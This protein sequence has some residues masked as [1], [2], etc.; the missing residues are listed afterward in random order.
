MK[1]LN[2][3][4][5]G[6]GRSGR[7]IHAANLQRLK[8]KFQVTAI[9]EP[10]EKRRERAEKEF[11]CAV[12][13]DYTELFAQVSEIDLVVNS[14]PSHFHVPVTLDLLKNGF[15][16]LCEKP[17]ARTA[18]EVDSMIETAEK[19]KRLLAVFQQSRFNESYREV[20]RIIDSGILG[21]II[22][23]SV[24]YSGFARR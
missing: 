6:Q 5:L 16:V 8:E 13:T 19:N 15:N 24:Q 20:K 14:T 4:I 3:A 7:D 2:V 17:F 1:K 22:Q 12:Y 10:L 9:V 18:E 21:R 11:G 23:I